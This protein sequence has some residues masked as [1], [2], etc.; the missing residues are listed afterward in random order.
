VIR[1]LLVDDSRLTREFL[2]E[3]LAGQ[4][5]LVSGHAYNG[6]D[7]I[8][9]HTETSPDV[10]V[11]DAMMPKLDGIGGGPWV[12]RIAEPVAFRVGFTGFSYHQPRI[13]HQPRP[14]LSQ[15]VMWKIE[16]NN[17]T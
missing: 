10:V 5:F 15:T 12:R 1:A 3:A 9:A 14:T 11:M 13:F 6:L 7:A 17:P 4:V 16:T 2:K 8:R